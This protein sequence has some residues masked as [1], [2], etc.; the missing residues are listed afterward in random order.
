MKVLLVN[1][2]ADDYLPPPAIGYLQAAVR[3][4]NTEVKSFNLEQALATQ[5]SFDIVGVSFHSFSVKY[6]RQ[7]RDKF[8]G[9]LICGGH[10]P[11]ALP[12]QML[13]IGYDQVV[14]GEG[15]NTMISILQGNK[16]K[17][18]YGSDWKHRY[19]FDINSYPIP[20]YTGINF[21]GCAGISIITSRGCPFACNFCASSDFWDHKYK[22]RS[23]DNV[24]AEIEQRIREGYTT[25]I[26][27][28][29]NFTMNRNRTIE[30]C[31]HLTGKYLWQCTSRAESLDA[32]LCRELYR[33]GCRKIWLG[34][35]S[36]SQS[37]LDRCNKHTTVEKMLTGI[38]N[39]YE[40]G[41]PT[42]S[43]FIVGLPGD[44]EQDINIT[45]EHIR[46]STITEIG[47]NTAWILPGTE[48]YRKAKEYGFDEQIFL[49]SGA[50]Y[51]LY[52]QTFETLKAW[53]Y[54]IMTAK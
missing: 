13:S 24:L 51:Y 11:S 45:A 35:E 2:W 1:P 32:D 3:N 37:A 21:G 44:T 14:I 26:F 15:E 30:I 5:E 49:E 46:R 23:P 20:D 54:K 9:H 8:K 6:A 53:E 47:V 17:I 39:A 40:A 38:S 16:N 43:L 10:H 27:E 36:L 31:R 12:D 50:P 34:V 52:E 28:D 19:Y 7:L 29:D 18:V 4:W 33:A 25:W 42:I 48:I 22:M 41:I